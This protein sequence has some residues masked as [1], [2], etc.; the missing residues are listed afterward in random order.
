MAIDRSIITWELVFSSKSYAEILNMLITNYRA[1]YGSDIDL[2]VNTADGEHLR[3]IATLL[4][5]FSN[6]AHDAYYSLDANN[7]KGALLDNIMFLSGNLIRKTP[8][9]TKITGRLEYVGDNISYETANSLILIQD[10]HNRLWRVTPMNNINQTING[11]TGV[12][13]NV[14]CLTV[15][16]FVVEAPIINIMH[17]GDFITGDSIVLSSDI[18][19]QRG[20]IEETDAQLRARKKETL[21]YNSNYLV[22]SIRDEV[23]NRIYSIQDIKIYNANK[24]DHANDNP[25]IVSGLDIKLWDGTSVEDV[26]IPLH[27]VFVLIKPQEGVTISEGG[28]ISKTLVEIL[29]RKITLGISTYQNPALPGHNPLGVNYQEEDI[30]LDNQFPGYFETIKYYIAQPYSPNIEIRLTPINGGFAEAEIRSRV[31]EALYLLARDYPINK[32]IN[33]AEI[34]NEVNQ[35]GNIDP[36]NPTFIIDDIVVTGASGLKTNNGYWYIDSPDSNKITITDT[37]L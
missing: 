15:G 33:I 3:L 20:S 31:R 10:N 35:K 17:N 37:S 27:D 30:I 2:Y 22:D 4:T 23:L 12:D 8:M 32:N 25:I 1:I 19:I 16:D 6:L 9:K 24:D 11:T 26:V 14:E 21:A 28:I 34:L 5:E 36:T 7:A 18:I 29:R 13:V